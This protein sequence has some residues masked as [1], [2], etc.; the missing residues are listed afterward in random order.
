[1]NRIQQSMS[2]FN[3]NLTSLFRTSD[4]RRRD[5]RHMEDI[6]ANI[7]SQAVTLSVDRIFSS[8][9]KLNAQSI[10]YFVRALCE[11]SWDEI[12]S[13][14]DRVCLLIIINI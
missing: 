1:M 6:Y 2:A 5:T 8:S 12:I 4:Q 14:S 10:I 3:E 13:S 9:S 11:M 7:N